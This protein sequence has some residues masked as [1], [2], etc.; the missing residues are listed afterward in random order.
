MKKDY[1]LI[2]REIDE[3][4]GV[5]KLVTHEERLGSFKAAVSSMN[6][7]AQGVWAEIY[8]EFKDVA[9]PGNVILPE[10]QEKGF[11][12]SCGWPEFMEKI[13]LLKHY[14]DHTE[15]LCDK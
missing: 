2:Q 6:K 3:E 9:T 1:K 13:W 10:A 15:R 4:N 5:H 8:S 11:I 7:D 12:P 14:L